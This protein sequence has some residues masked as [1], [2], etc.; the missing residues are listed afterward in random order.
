MSV[1][2]QIDK[3]G[4][5]TYYRL[6]G[7]LHRD[8]DLPAI[9]TPYGHGGWYRHGQI[10]RDDDRPALIDGIS[11]EWYQNGILH[12]DGENPAVMDTNGLHVWYKYGKPY[13][14]E[15]LKIYYNR[16]EPFARHIIGKYRINRLKRVRWIHGELL[17]RPPR[18]NFPGGQDYYKMV[19]YFNNY[20]N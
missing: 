18:G 3:Y 14:L 7:Q 10:H 8:G 6:N 4:P 1:T 15:K 20:N 19:N 17:C 5:T 9:E 2:I 12:R 13:T 11:K 16:L